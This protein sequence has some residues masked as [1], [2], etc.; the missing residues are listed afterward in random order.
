MVH[1]AA[2]IPSK[3]MYRNGEPSAQAEKSY[4]T[5]SNNG[6]PIKVPRIPYPFRSMM[7]PMPDRIPLAVGLRGK[8]G[9][10]VRAGLLLL[11]FFA[12]EGAL[13][14]VDLKTDLPLQERLGQA[15]RWRQID[16]PSGIG[17]LI[18]IQSDNEGG[19]LALYDRNSLLRYD[20]YRWAP[21]P[22]SS[23]LQND[24][25]IQVRPLGNGVLTLGRHFVAFLDGSGSAEIFPITGLDRYHRLVASEAVGDRILMGRGSEIF[26]VD[27]QGIHEH[28]LLPTAA[29]PLRSLAILPEDESGIQVRA[30]AMCWNGLYYYDG[31]R[32]HKSADLPLTTRQTKNLKLF[33]QEKTLWLLPIGRARMHTAYRRVV[34]SWVAIDLG[35]AIRG[36][37]VTKNQ[38]LLASADAGG[39]LLFEDGVLHQAAPARQL[40][41]RLLAIR[42]LDDDRLAVVEA[43]GRIWTCD[44]ESDRWRE[45]TPPGNVERP[46]VLAIA[47][48]SRGG[49]WLGTNNGLYRWKDGVFLD[50]F[51]RVLDIDLTTITGLQED[52]RGHLWVGSGSSFVGALEFDGKMW[53]HH[54]EV[55]GVGDFSVH[56]IRRGH[57]DDLWFLLL[58]RADSYAAPWG[59]VARLS[60]GK[61]KRF[62]EED[63]LPSART[64][65]LTTKFNH[66]VLIGTL[67]GIARLEGERWVAPPYATTSAARTLFFSQHEE[68]WIGSGISGRGISVVTREGRI[69]DRGDLPRFAAA[70]F[71]DDDKGNTWIS[72]PDGLFRWDGVSF[73]DVTR[74]PGIPSRVFWPIVTCG[75][76]ALCMGSFGQGLVRFEPDDIDPP[77]TEELIVSPT[78]EKDEFLIRWEGRDKWN[79]TLA[80]DLRF[81]WRIDGGPWST[82]IRAR[83]TKVKTSEWGAIE[84]EAQAIDLADNHETIP[85]SITLMTPR[86]WWAH[87]SLV[88]P[89]VFLFLALFYLTKTTMT[90]KKER[91]QLEEEK[92]RAASQL[93]SIVE[94]TSELI[95]IQSI[96]DGEYLFVS[97]SSRE[98]TG[99]TPEEFLQNQASLIDL[100]HPASRGYEELWKKIC[101]EEFTRIPTYTVAVRTKS[102][103][104][105]IQQVHES[106]M[107]Q[108]GR[109][110]VLG[111]AV[112]ITDI[113]QA[114]EAMLHAEK[115]KSLGVL[116]GGIA[117][118]FNN[119]LVGILG[120][121]EL[122]G[123][124]VG[125]DLES[126]RYLD[127]IETSGRKAAG[128]CRQMLTYAGKIRSTP[129]AIDMPLLL[130]EVTGLA[131]AAVDASTKFDICILDE[132]CRISG[133]PTQVHQV[134]MNLIINGSDALG[135]QPGV[136]NISMDRVTLKDGDI[137]KMAPFSPSPGEF[138]RVT[139]QDDG[140]GMDKETLLRIFDPFFSTKI[141]GRGLGLAAVRG[142]VH[143]HNGALTV[144]SRPGCGSTFCIYLPVCLEPTES[145]AHTAHS[146]PTAFGY[147]T[148][149]VVDDEPTVSRVAKLILE[150]QGF[151]VLVADSGVEGIEVIK[152][153]KARIRAVVLDLT[154]PDRDGLET[155]VE[156]RKIIPKLPAVLCSGYVMENLAQRIG[157]IDDLFFLQKPF[158]AAAM[159]TA[160]L[161]VLPDDTRGKRHPPNLD[162]RGKPL[163]TTP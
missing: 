152:T 157:E 11:C 23:A 104:N 64:Y 128:L 49:F 136:V 107:D 6:G 91:K 146:K 126:R 4:R 132:D 15:W 106:Y 93:R 89:L 86:P 16:P 139:V 79:T 130:D 60:R 85:R 12:G 80:E 127:E 59:G 122:L 38:T 159:A 27:S 22:G 82:P 75:R 110:V 81:R 137:S 21:Y 57:G 5:C 76:N 32:W 98:L 55:E 131:R 90:Q 156:M 46:S 115:L 7:M 109:R 162:N 45:F 149:L 151:S 97:P 103:E 26:R 33:F 68:L 158:D 120:N 108:D 147:G 58:G 94:N 37:V 99:Y 34:D 41:E 48:S 24:P 67:K 18:G 1:A 2:R 144:E 70:G 9:F 148:I 72:S 88:A 78:L 14:A 63:G 42:V 101:N 123:L 52:H 44:I 102:G 10:G 133:D 56:A 125:G 35:T 50:S 116:A 54:T 25:I 142:I 160:L 8:L 3:E 65:D 112:D 114:H 119:L 117:H 143:S 47:R 71:V 62:G 61:W 87:W 83:S 36:V 153:S 134:L 95:Y 77:V 43:S 121:A 20:G 30:W 28:S 113:R 17:Q 138:V 69:D 100:E 74:E 118:D 92:D 73:S 105:R 29:G 96:P 135:G 150:K 161:A 145:T 163:S 141:Q 154:M 111:I 39:F 129:T 140:C 51:Q 84:F 53:T 124:N 40:D 19:L 31:Q 155:L 66:Q 13:A